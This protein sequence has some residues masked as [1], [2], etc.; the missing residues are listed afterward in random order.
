MDSPLPVHARS[1]AA[2]WLLGERVL[3]SSAVHARLE[4]AMEII[5]EAAKRMSADDDAQVELS[6]DDRDFLNNVRLMRSAALEVREMLKVEIP[7]RQLKLATDSTIEFP[8]PYVAARAYMS[9]AKALFDEDVFVEYMQVFEEQS[10]FEMHEIWALKP[11]M[12][13]IGRAHV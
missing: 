2:E 4:R 12:Q 1:R 3:G 5:G 7:I 6:V 9:V 13:M 8:R 11:A 10:F